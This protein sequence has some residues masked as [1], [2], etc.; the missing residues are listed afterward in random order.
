MLP[1]KATFANYGGAKLDYSPAE[2]PTTDRAAVELNEALADVAGMTRMVGRAYVVFT[3]DN[4]TS[5]CT[6]VDHDAVWGSDVSVKPTVSYDGG[7]AYA[8]DW[9]GSVTDVHGVDHP[10]N[11]RA[12]VA[13]VA[14][15]AWL[16]NVTQV[17]GNG[18][19]LAAYDIAGAAQGDPASTVKITVFV[20]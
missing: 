1:N 13:N 4:A 14:A 7:G 10:V 18:V 20:W 8:V 19:L 15:L 3:V 16:C 12:G 17:G 11:L 6:V 9:P 5:T 2:D